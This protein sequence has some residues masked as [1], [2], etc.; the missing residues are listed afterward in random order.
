[1]AVL[2]NFTLNRASA[3]IRVPY[4]VAADFDIAPLVDLEEAFTILPSELDALPATLNIM[5]GRLILDKTRL[6]VA[7]NVIIGKG[8][9]LDLDYAGTLPALAASGATP[10]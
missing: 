10:H 3:N 4:S 2:N 5:A 8:G 1:M 7:G 6:N 9:I